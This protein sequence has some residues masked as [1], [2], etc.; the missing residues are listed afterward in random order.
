MIFFNISTGQ[1]EEYTYQIK[2]SYDNMAHLGY[3]DSVAKIPS[4]EKGDLSEVPSRVMSI[5]L[6]TQLLLIQKILRQQI[7]INLQTGKSITQHKE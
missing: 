3:Q 7:Q 1:Y 5:L 6:M 4:N 2:D